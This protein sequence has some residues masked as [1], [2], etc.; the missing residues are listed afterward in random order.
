MDASETEE[1]MQRVLLIDLE[2]CP[3]QINQLMDSLE[4]YTYVV[5][6]Y[7]HSGAKI[8][9]DWIIPLTRTVNNSKLR[10]TKM[11]S[12]GKNSAD[13]GIAF[14]SGVLMMELPENTH[15][16]IIS[17]DNDLE[18][19]VNLLKDQGRSAERIAIKRD[20]SQHAA[21]L[22]E[23]NSPEKNAYLQEYCLHLLAHNKSRP[24]KKETLINNIKSKFKAENVNPELIFDTLCRQ[25]VIEVKDNK[26]LYNQYKI[27][28]IAP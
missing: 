24:A 6:C 11:A 23:S 14:W 7:A 16:D 25:G 3:S 9:I 22:K 10:I 1:D 2:N 18:H 26:I 8:P 5:V 17:N 27:T 15:F 19:V 20:N 28:Q 12:K 4:Q 21:V 13:F